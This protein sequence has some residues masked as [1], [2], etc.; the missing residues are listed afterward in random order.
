MLDD[1]GL[2][3]SIPQI[4][5]ETCADQAQIGAYVRKLVKAGFA[6]VVAADSLNN[7]PLAKEYRLL[8]NPKEAPRIRADGTVIVSSQ[9]ECLWRAMRALKGGFNVRELAYAATTD[10][11]TIK[12]VAAQRYVELLA[13]A[14]YLT[15]VQPRRGRHGMNTWRLK[16]GMNTGPLSP[17]IFKAEAIFDRNLRKIM[18]EPVAQEVAS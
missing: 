14:G 11:V 18:G 8:M 10:G 3:W 17:T 1:K 2:P 16:P 9:Q 15:I 13:G 4:E 5:A 12:E 6:R 7:R